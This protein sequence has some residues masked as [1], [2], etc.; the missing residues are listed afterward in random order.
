MKKKKITALTLLLAS[1]A[2]TTAIGGALLGDGVA[3]GADEKSYALT[4]V[5]YSANDQ[6]IT[7]SEV[8]GKTVTA[9]AF[10]DDTSVTLKRNMAIKWFAGAGVEK[11]FTL[12]FAFETLEFSKVTVTVESSSAWATEE[13]K[14]TNVVE[15]TKDADKYFVAVNPS[16]E[17]TDKTEVSLTAGEVMTLTLADGENDGEF[18]VLL[19]GNEIGKF[20]NVG[21]NYAEYSY[22]DTY[23]LTIKADLGDENVAADAKVKVLLYELN[24]Q[25]FDNITEGKVMDN[26]APVVVVNE[27]VYGFL[28][29]TA[30]SLDYTVIDVLKDKNLTKTLEYY[31]YNP[32]IAED[33]EAFEKFKTLSTSTYFYP[34]TYTPSGETKTT[35]VYNEEGAEYVAVKVTVGDDAFNQSPT[36]DSEYKKA[37]Y[38]L[39]WYVVDQTRVRTD[40]SDNGIGFIAADRNE[41]GATY[42]YITADPD[43]VNAEDKVNVV[44]AQL[45]TA[46][47]SF[48]DALAKAAKDVYAGSNS[49]IYF[50]SFEWLIADNN[51]YRNLKFTI[52]YKAYGADSAST[53][54]SLSYNALKLA[55]SKEGE[56]EFKVFANDK[57]GNTMKY[58]LD[59]ELVSVTS[60]NV[61]DIEEIP[62]FT[63]SIENKGLKVDDGKT[64]SERK[65]TEV[66]DETFTLE[67]MTVVGATNLQESYKLY[68]VDVQKFNNNKP[69][70]ASNI[71]SNYLT[72]ITYETIANAVATK[73]LDQV[74]N[75]E[76]HKFYL[77]VYA[78]LIGER[79]NATAEEVLA[80]GCFTEIGVAGDRVNNAT[81]EFEAYAWNPTAQSFKTVEEG[82]YLIVADYWEKEIPSQRAMAYK[83]ITVES[84]AA[85]IKGETDWLKNNVVSVVLFSIAGVM[86][87]LIIILL[88]VKPS[89][90]TLEDVDEKVANKAKMKKN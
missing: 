89:D 8:G 1:A 23:P 73:G 51:G 50:P 68:K 67:D 64:A 48:D 71:L 81:D 4:D 86:L 63:F 35:T 40:L 30:F 33:D 3:A 75:K 37:V 2:V 69:E 18:K 34:T 62:S 16:E 56:Y 87:I 20:E 66:R 80:T 90:E 58:Y 44:D 49:Y 78:S 19:S 41:D 72:D 26:A 14:A 84:E 36:E 45:E 70:G 7:S 22:N 9:F 17:N 53:S 79:V 12:K 42:N 5:F 25:S 6:V 77:E 82:E 47:K 52:S 38:D 57:A 59:G 39:S 60:S 46:R 54:S 88:L 21:A 85:T 61:W 55:V 83:L 28:L 65:E 27:D 24:G 32:S 11:Y 43:A 29:G 10:A 31:Q 74:E 15:F 76:Y 13:E